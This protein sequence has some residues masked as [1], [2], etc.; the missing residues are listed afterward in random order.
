MLRCRRSR[1]NNE[2]P[3][4][5]RLSEVRSLKQECQGQWSINIFRP[6]MLKEITQGD[7]CE[8][9]RLGTQL[10]GRVLA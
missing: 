7:V 9:E 1:V 4:R 5:S 3:V 10:S 6:V 2:L 8:K